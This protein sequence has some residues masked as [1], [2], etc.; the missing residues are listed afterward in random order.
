MSR[1]ISTLTLFS[2]LWIGT[3]TA[4]NAEYSAL[5]TDTLNRAFSQRILFISANINYLTPFL[6]IEFES[7]YLF[8]TCKITMTCA[9]EIR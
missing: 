5:P 3:L 4:R 8:L 2:R 6:G 1:K 9:I 7:K